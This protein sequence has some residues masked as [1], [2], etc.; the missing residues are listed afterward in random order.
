MTGSAIFSSLPATRE[1]LSELLQPNPGDL[2]PTREPHARERLRVLDKPL[3]GI[4]RSRKA[5]ETKVQP[6]RHHL[7]RR[8]ALPIELIAIFLQAAEEVIDVEEAARV[9]IALV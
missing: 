3:H 8:R 9:R 4:R 6:D 1:L 7:W 5:R 2:G